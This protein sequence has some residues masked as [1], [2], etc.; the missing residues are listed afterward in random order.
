[1]SAVIFDVEDDR[2]TRIKMTSSQ[3]SV[4]AD[5]NTETIDY[6]TFRNSFDKAYN[7]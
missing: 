4:V 2:R 6:E 7:T 1:M 5:T 3:P